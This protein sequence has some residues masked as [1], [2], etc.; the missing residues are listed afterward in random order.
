MEKELNELFQLLILIQIGGDGR[1]R[2][3]NELLQILSHFLRGK[4]AAY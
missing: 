1:P 4:I 3:F 2:F